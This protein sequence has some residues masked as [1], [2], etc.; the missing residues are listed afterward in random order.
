MM[1]TKVQNKVVEKEVK[2][3]TDNNKTE[4]QIFAFI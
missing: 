3:V 1:E 2:N 4:N